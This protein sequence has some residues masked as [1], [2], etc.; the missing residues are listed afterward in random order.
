MLIKTHSLPFPFLFSL[1]K[2][3][4]H[5]CSSVVLSERSEWKYLLHSLTFHRKRNGKTLMLIKTHSLPFPFLFPCPTL[6][7]WM[8]F[9]HLERQ[10]RGLMAEA[11]SSTP[12]LRTYARNNRK[13]KNRRK[14]KFFSRFFFF[15]MSVVCFILIFV[16]RRC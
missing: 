11:D 16:L 12:V 7:P 4:H 6:S 1:S 8:L 14:E 2:R 9:C 10:S 5:G 15:R 3:W 13:S